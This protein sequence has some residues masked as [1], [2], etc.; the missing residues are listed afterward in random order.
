MKSPILCAYDIWTFDFPQFPQG[1]TKPGQ[2]Q[3]S[4]YCIVK[5]P[6]YTHSQ[7]WMKSPLLYAY[8]LWLP[9]PEVDQS[10]DSL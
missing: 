9:P 2:T 3:W 4:T 7:V 8:E 10:I 1:S 6:I 5:Q